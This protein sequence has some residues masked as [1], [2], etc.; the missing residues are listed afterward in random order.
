MVGNYVIFLREY[1]HLKSNYSLRNPLNVVSSY[2]IQSEHKSIFFKETS[3][4]FENYELISSRFSSL[5]K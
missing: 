1:L 5:G 2:Q 3:I 4:C